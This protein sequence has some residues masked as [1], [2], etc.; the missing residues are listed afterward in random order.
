MNFNTDVNHKVLGSVLEKLQVL[1]RVYWIEGEGS[2]DSMPSSSGWFLSTELTGG[3]LPVRVYYM[4]VGD[5][6]VVENETPFVS[7]RSSPC[8]RADGQPR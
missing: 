6:A 8:H 4:T 5:D 2:S 1:W 7:L 3:I